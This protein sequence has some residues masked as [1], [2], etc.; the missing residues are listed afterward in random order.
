MEVLLSHVPSI[1]TG[2]KRQYLMNM[3]DGVE[4]PI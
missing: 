3:A 4:L 1:G 2:Q